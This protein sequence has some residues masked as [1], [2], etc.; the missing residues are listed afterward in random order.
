MKRNQYIQAPKIND[1][2]YHLHDFKVF[3]KLDLKQGYHQLTLNLETRKVATFS[4]PSGTYGPKQLI[5][6][7]KSSQDVLDKAMFK[8]FGDIQHCLNQR[9]ILMG[10]QDN[11]EYL[12]YR[13]SYQ[14][15]VNTESP[16]TK[17]SMNLKRKK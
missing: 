4:T 9:D 3:S 8:A 7:A 1:F 2:I 11:E 5:F 14:E 16:S 12:S 13:R 15:Q 10:G 6:V 17:R